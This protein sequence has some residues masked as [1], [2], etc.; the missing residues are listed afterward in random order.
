MAVAVGTGGF[1]MTWE[2]G[3][4]RIEDPGTPHTLLAV[5]ARADGE[6]CAV[7]SGGV[8]A[9]RRGG[10]WTAVEIPGMGTLQRLA[11]GGEDLWACGEALPTLKVR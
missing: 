3:D 8:L 4:W 7:G 1:A 2:G 10:S 9:R 11:T 6:V 5:A